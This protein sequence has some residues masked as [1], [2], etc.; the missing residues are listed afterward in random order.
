MFSFRWMRTRSGRLLATLLTTLVVLGL[1]AGCS[2]SE[3]KPAATPAPAAAAPKTMKIGVAVSMTGN[4]SKEGTLMKQGYDFWSEKVNAAGGIKV[5]NDTYKVELVYYDDKSDTNTSVKLTEKLITE[6]KV[7]FIFG[8]YSSG[9]TQATSAISEKYKIITIG[10][11][12]NTP[13][14]YERNFKYLF[15]TLPLAPTYLHP[16]IE[17]AATLDPK[18]KTAAIIAPDN[19]FALSAAEGAKAKAEALGMQVVLNEKFP[20]GAKDVSSLLSQV[21]AKNPDMLLVAGFF[22]DGT[23][24]VSQLK[25][26]KWSPKLL[27]FTI[28]A[29][30]PDFRKTLGADAENVFGAEWWLPNMKYEDKFYGSARKFADDFKARYGIE[31]TYHAASPAVSGLILQKALEKAGS[32]DSDK[33]ADALRTLDIETFFGKIKFDAQGRNV[34]GVPGAFQIQKGELIELWPKD[35]V[36]GKAVY[37]RP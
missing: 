31:P 25:E 2:K 10:T 37:P 35:I 33:V 7:S 1:V 23:L 36:R 8:P 13:A 24:V 9:I 28:A 18:P 16:V 5:G 11:T 22:T 3:P 34:A 30:I 20:M 12:A 6:D 19:L 4:F 27:A 21:K 15:G 29:S 32:L 17:F 14:L 26:L